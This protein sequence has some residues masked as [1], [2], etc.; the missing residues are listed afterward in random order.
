MGEGAPKFIPREEVT[1]PLADYNKGREERND[2]SEDVFTSA[3]QLDETNSSFSGGIDYGDDKFREE[4]YLKAQREIKAEKPRTDISPRTNFVDAD[5]RPNSFVDPDAPTL[6]LERRQTPTPP[7]PDTLPVIDEEIDEKIEELDDSDIIEDTSD[8]TPDAE[9]EAF[10]G[11]ERMQT[12]EQANNLRTEALRTEVNNW[13]QD[14]D[15]LEAQRQQEAELKQRQMKAEEARADKIQTVRNQIAAW[16]DGTDNSAIQ[17]RNQGLNTN[18]ELPPLP[19]SQKTEGTRNLQT[20]TL[21]EAGNI[22]FTGETGTAIQQQFTEAAKKLQELQ[23]LI[24]SMPDD[25]PTTNWQEAKV[26]TRETRELEELDLKQAIERV[27]SVKTASNER[28]AEQ[29]D[30]E[31]R[32]RFSNIDAQLQ[33]QFQTF[34]DQFGNLTQAQNERLQPLHDALSEA[35]RENN[36]LKY[37]NIAARMQKIL[38][39]FTESA[40]MR[41]G[42]STNTLLRNENRQL[43]KDAQ[44]PIS[45]EEIDR[46]T[47]PKS[48]IKTIGSFFG[49]LFRK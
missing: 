37:E 44:K 17:L 15:A 9:E 49:S 45:Q 3:G 32:K 46:A 2:D 38:E 6:R 1:I 36:A 24:Q 25:T 26:T 18:N 23:N 20:V 42:N 14:I 19:N 35:Q 27:E 22:Q 41:Q 34:Q 10:L 40:F 28:E 47:K 13:S 21:N 5:A 33:K 16:D 43:Q 31:N 30:R 11:E 12:R 8:L 7:P 39:T 4:R 48:I 29:K